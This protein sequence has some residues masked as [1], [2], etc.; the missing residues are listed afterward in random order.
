MTGNL[1]IQEHLPVG[2][3]ERHPDAHSGLGT[4]VVRGGMWTLGGQ[5][6]LLVTSLFITPFVLRLLA[7]SVYGAYSLINS[8]VAYL[9]F[10]DLGMGVASTRFASQAFAAGNAEAESDAIWTSFAITA[11]VTS[12]TVAVLALAA[13]WL[14]AS[15]L[16][17]PSSIQPATIIGLRLALLG[18]LARS[19]G[20]IWNTSQ[21]VRLRFD[22]Y[23]VINS[24]SY[25]AQSLLIFG[26][27]W[28]GHGLVTAGAIMATMGA[29]NALGHLWA[30]GRLQPAI[31]H[32][33]LDPT[34]LKPLLRFGSP[35]VFTG[36]VGTAL[37]H[38]ERFLLVRY[39]SVEALAY[40]SVAFAIAQL[41]ELA[42]NALT[43]GLLPAFSRLRE[44][45]G[46]EH[47]RFL[48][49]QSLQGTILT[50]VPVALLLGLAGRRFLALWAGP[51]YGAHST[52]PL[53]LLL[54][55]FVLNA[56]GHMPRTLLISYGRTDIIARCHAAEVIP[57]LAIA[58][59]LIGRFGVVGA[60][61]AW[62]IR[63]S[64][65]CLVMLP[66]TGNFCGVFWLPGKAK[67][68]GYLLSL[69][70]LL[71]PVAVALALSFPTPILAGG[72]IFSV[73]AYARVVWSL[74]LNDEERDLLSL[75]A[76]RLRGQ[77]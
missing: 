37:F 42:P 69:A 23:T 9:A 70:A 65:E 77:P 10:T 26:A 71:V 28:L 22:V 34:I 5:A 17:V 47:L 46:H 3:A 74:V 56:V 4:R 54:A 44:G 24:G 67:F 2:V 58:V 61:A 13:H 30:S 53:Y 43:Q 49:F 75:Q 66:L 6:V 73:A 14:I 39:A 68:R 72:T 19:L 32:P 57:Y 38:G 12:I 51:T 62:A 16:H 33:R 21:V 25:L 55:G 7:P 52:Y 76:L 36:L 31:Y 45:S 64:A 35:I 41:L 50:I 29:V 40:Y 27:F 11:L 59:F 60:A 63:A 48:Y 8:V 20:G 1:S 18:L 15:G